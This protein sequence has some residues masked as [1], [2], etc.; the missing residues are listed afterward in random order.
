MLIRITHLDISEA[1]GKPMR[2]SLFVIL[3]MVAGCSGTDPAPTSSTKNMPA[4][5]C[6]T[7]G[8][9]YLCSFVVESGTCPAIADQVQNINPDG[10]LVVSSSFSCSA[11]T[12]NGCTTNKTNCTTSTKDAQGVTCNSTGNA[13]STFSS[14]GSSVNGTESMMVDCSDGSSCNGTYQ[15]SCARQ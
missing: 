10:T 13:T 11:V 3:L 5:P 6:A 4:N 1:K 12:V 9:S 15:V 7:P 8:A 14:D 2:K